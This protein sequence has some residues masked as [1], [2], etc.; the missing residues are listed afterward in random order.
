MKRGKCSSSAAP[1]L[2]GQQ[3]A[4]QFGL[5][6]L[7]QATRN[8]DESNLIGCGSFGL[9]FKGLLCDGTVVAVKRHT[10]APQPEFSE[11]V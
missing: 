1:T 8:F 3:E 11:E 5:E 9:V 4:R 10:G 7:E 6:D 2:Q